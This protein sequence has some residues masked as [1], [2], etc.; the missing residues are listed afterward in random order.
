MLAMIGKRLAV[1]LVLLWVVATVVF[2]AL[3]MVP[4]DPARIILTGTGATPTEEAIQNLREQ[5]GLHL[6]LWEQYTR[7]LGQLLT[8]SL[9]E[10]LRSGTP[11]TELVGQRLPR[12]L[13]L[14]FATTLVSVLFGVLFGALAGRRGGWI[15]RVLMVV[16]S[17]S[18]AIPAYV[19]A[20]VLVYF[21]GVQM[22]WLP[23]G[24]YVP[25]SDD[26]VGHIQTLIMPTISLSLAFTAVVARMTRTAVLSVGE[27]DWVRTGRSVGLK[28]SRVFS[29]HVLRNSLTSVVTVS[30]LQMGALL[31]GTVIVERVF[32]WPGLS[33]LLINGVTTRDYPVVQ[34]TVLVIAALFVLLN[35]VVDILY[36]FIDP[37]GRD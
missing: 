13:Q 23:S 19:A 33:E 31:G 36:G 26:P 18:V 30:G 15:D 7:F 17:F 2:L 21:V 22:Q 25:F 11:V 27:Q 12:T 3:H 8:G 4:G 24:G 32:S 1:G 29:R 37:R 5:L 28:E 34:G 10:S 16:T 14:V 35:I 20:V 6:P 9:G